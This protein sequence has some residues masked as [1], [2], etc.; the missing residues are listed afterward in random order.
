[1]SKLPDLLEQHR[2]VLLR[3]VQQRGGRLL[4][5][6]AAEDLVQGVHVRVLE[7]GGGFAY[8]GDG[9]FLAW[10]RTVARSYLADRI[11][12]WTAQ[13]RRPAGLLRLTGAG[14]TDSDAAREP[15]GEGTGPATFAE[16]REMLAAATAALDLLLPRDRELLQ[17]A[18]EGWTVGELAEHLG[19]SYGAADK[20]RT[21]AIE[22]FR[23]AYQVVTGT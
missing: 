11:T 20:A 21:R 13:R 16:R 17:L 2:A 4:R 23:K 14:G 3:F 12:Y 6:E 18:A 19:L 15:A 8:R 1:M 5:Y 10:L 7:R 22:R 9:P